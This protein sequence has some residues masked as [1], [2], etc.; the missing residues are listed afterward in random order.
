MGINVTQRPSSRLDN[1]IEK[2]LISVTARLLPSP[3][4]FKIPR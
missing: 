3:V 4:I 2:T 1:A